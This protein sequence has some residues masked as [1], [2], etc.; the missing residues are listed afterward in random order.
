MR[1]YGSEHIGYHR[2]ITRDQVAQHYFLTELFAIIV[3]V[4]LVAD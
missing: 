3:V 1:G 2:K 4:E